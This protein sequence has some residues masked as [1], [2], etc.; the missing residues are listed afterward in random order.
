M[1]NAMWEGKNKLSRNIFTIMRDSI[2]T[3]SSPI[4]THIKEVKPIIER[5][6][7]SGFL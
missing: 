5:L 2:L 4:I 3:I 1:L 7:K 6:K